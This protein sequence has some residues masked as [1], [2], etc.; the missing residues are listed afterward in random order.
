MTEHRP[1]KEQIQIKLV[2]VAPVTSVGEQKLI[3]AKVESASRLSHPAIVPMYDFGFADDGIPYLVAEKIDE[4]TIAEFLKRER[5]DAQTALEY[6]MQL[7][8][9]LALA[10]T[11]GVT[12]GNIRASNIFVGDED[13][14]GNRIRLGCFGLPAQEKMGPPTMSDDVVALGKVLSQLVDGVAISPEF[15]TVIDFCLN[16][17]AASRYKDGRE[18]LENLLLVRQR[19]LPQPPQERPG[20]KLLSKPVIT[21][22]IMVAVG[23]TALLVLAFQSSFHLAPTSNLP[24]STPQAVQSAPTDQAVVRSVNQPGQIRSSAPIQSP[25]PLEVPPSLGHLIS[26]DK[27]KNAAV[28][29]GITAA[30]AYQTLDGQQKERAR[31]AI[32]HG[33]GSGIH[34][35]QTMDSGARDSLKQKA[36]NAAHK[37]IGLWH[38]LP[39]K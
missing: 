6:S 9:A 38:R 18:V 14:A 28:L 20:Q 25:A 2:E 30:A 26:K 21:G 10:H 15:G 5:L 8:E 37:A 32:L 31:S 13:S 7:A 11:M 23:I 24:S 27:I 16:R 33:A 12:H 4:P 1:P 34:K 17:D 19:K 29:G 39:N 22:A 35:W 36:S 3:K